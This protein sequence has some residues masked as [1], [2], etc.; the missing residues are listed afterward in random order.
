[1]SG[2]LRRPP[3]QQ[4]GVHGLELDSVIDKGSIARASRAA[5]LQFGPAA[6]GRQSVPAF[7]NIGGFADEQ[8][9]AP[10]G[11]PDGRAHGLPRR[12]TSTRRTGKGRGRWPVHHG[13]DR[14]P[15]AAAMEAAEEG[16]VREQLPFGVEDLLRPSL[17]RTVAHCRR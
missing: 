3:E 15:A 8:S 11:R 5:G 7:M 4:G 6:E 16:E 1:M 13:E 17:L 2:D 10:F 9:V 12:N 14:E